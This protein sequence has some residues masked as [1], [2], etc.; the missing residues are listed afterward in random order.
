MLFA[1]DEP[2]EAGV[3]AELDGERP[4][5]VRIGVVDLA[6]DKVLLRLRRKVDPSWI[7]SNARAEFASGID[8]CGLALDVHAAVGANS[9]HG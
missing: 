6:A 9:G 7:S 3:A 5:Q 4:H 8:S 2:G 1:I